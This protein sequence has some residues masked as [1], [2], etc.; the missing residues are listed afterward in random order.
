MAKSSTTARAFTLVELLVIISVIAILAGLLFSTFNSARNKAKR[1]TCLN[2]LKQINLGLRLYCDDAN[3]KSPDA[4]TSTQVR[5]KQF[6]KGYVGLTGPSSSQDKLFA[7]PADTFRYYASET[8][9]I[10][11]NDSRHD[12]TFSDFSSYSFNGFNLHP[13][14]DTHHPPAFPGIGG[15]RLSSIRNPAKTVLVAEDA[16]F[17]P[18]SWHEPRRPFRWENATYLDSRNMVSFVDGHVSYIKMYWNSAIVYPGDKNNLGGWG[19]MSIYYDPPDSY[20]YKWS[21][22]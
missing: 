7:C 12:G 14:T 10:G 1:A 13:V 20:D 19:S 6:M 15:K 8:Q 18:F 4:G 17:Y 11:T 2:N 21:G 9:T 22:D 3:D 16:A 5:Y